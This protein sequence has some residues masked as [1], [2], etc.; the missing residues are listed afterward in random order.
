MANIVDIQ[1]TE[2]GPRNSWF[3]VDV[4]LDTSDVTNFAIWDPKLHYV[5]PPPMTPTNSC[6]IQEIQY[7]IQNGLSV[8]LLWDAPV[9]RSIVHLEGRGKFPVDTGSGWPNDAGPG[10]SG[11]MLLSTQGW[12]TGSTL[13]ATLYIWVIKTVI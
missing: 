13:A 9:P 2:D 6:T 5:E 1:D 11:K 3:K 12:T 7:A 8:Q 10:T 4:T